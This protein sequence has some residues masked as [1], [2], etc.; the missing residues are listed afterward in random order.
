MNA[1]AQETPFETVLEST[2]AGL[3]EFNERLLTEAKKA[4]NVSLDAY[5]ATFKTLAEYTEK[6]GAA[7]PIEFVSTITAAQAKA[8]RE[9]TGA[10]AKAA[11]SLLN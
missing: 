2:T 3:R 11:R 8:T 7:S 4:G 5:E 10:Y 1:T 9:L 6:V